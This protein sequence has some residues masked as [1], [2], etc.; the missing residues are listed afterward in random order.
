MGSNIGPA[1]ANLYMDQFERDFVYSSESYINNVLIW[2]RFID[3]VFFI[4][5]GTEKALLEFKDT[6]DHCLPT[7]SFTIEHSQKQVH[8]LDVLISVQNGTLVTDQYCKPTDRTTYLASDSFH[9]DPLKKGLPYSQLIRLRRITSN[10][11][12]FNKRAEVMMQD[13]RTRGYDDI[14]LRTAYDKAF[15]Q[16]RSDLLRYRTKETSKRIPAVL[17]Y[18][19]ESAHVKKIVLR[20][21]HVLSSDSRL[22]STFCD[23]PMFAFKRASN[24][25]DRLIK[26]DTTRRQIP[27]EDTGSQ[28]LTERQRPRGMFQCG[29]CTYC[30]AAIKGPQFHHPLSGKIF[31]IR[32]FLTCRSTFV[33]YLLKCPCGKGYVGQTTRELRVRVG[34]HRSAIRRGD[35]TS[36]VAKHF[37][38]A[39]HSV[40]Q[41]RFMAIE[42]IKRPKRGGNMVNLLL[43]R[44]LHWIYTLQTRSPRGMNEEVDLSPFL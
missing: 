28:W 7:I 18:S 30:N 21:W 4:W 8:F 44:E 32:D 33:V 27:N 26:A 38:E 19:T 41:L 9:P 34:E 20:H 31:P 37:L 24:L 42:Q 14:T 6:L 3:D 35:L 12:M 36:P 5:Q 11:E 40:A 43:R 16:Q 15:Q 17:T 2:Y 22:Q 23:P 13:F 1:Y 25:R 39:Q 29:H 10:D